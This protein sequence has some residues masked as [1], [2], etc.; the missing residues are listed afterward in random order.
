MGSSLQLLTHTR[1]EVFCPLQS[2]MKFLVALLSLTLVHGAA[3]PGHDDHGHIEYQQHNGPHCHAMKDKSLDITIL[4]LLDMTPGLLMNIALIT[5]VMMIT[6]RGQPML[7]IMDTTVVL[8]VKTRRSRSATSIPMRTLARSPRQLARRLLT[9]STL[10][11]V[12]RSSTLSVR[13]LTSSIIPVSMLLG[14]NPMLLLDLL[15]SMRNTRV[16]VMDMVMVMGIREGTKVLF[17]YC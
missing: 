17:V 8:S 14:M 12:R 6:T 2:K 13:N 16:R 7:E 5:M 15:D 10:R 9:P 3:N 1:W 11:S 4:V